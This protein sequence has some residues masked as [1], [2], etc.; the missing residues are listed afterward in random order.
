M[1][2]LMIIVGLYVATGLSSATYADR[3]ISRTLAE[4]LERQAML[5]LETTHFDASFDVLNYRSKLGSGNAIPAQSGC[6]SPV[7]VFQ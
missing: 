4:G 1:R 2:T 3:T 5:T 6:R 7:V